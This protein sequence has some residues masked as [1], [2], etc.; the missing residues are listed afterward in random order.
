MKTDGD[1]LT[2]VLEGD[3]VINVY[4]SARP[5]TPTTPEAPDT[6]DR[7]NVVGYAGIAMLAV[8]VALLTVFERKRRA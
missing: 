6:G 2:G 1:E 8:G 7:T 5:E 3:V 4:Y